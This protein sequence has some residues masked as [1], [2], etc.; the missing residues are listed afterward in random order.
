MK[1]STATAPKGIR[2]GILL[3]PQDKKILK[4]LQK[5][6]TTVLGK[7]GNTEII[8]RALVDTYLGDGGE[9]R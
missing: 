7:P 3:R 5:R 1:N 6:W 8:R 9:A 2:I 4:A